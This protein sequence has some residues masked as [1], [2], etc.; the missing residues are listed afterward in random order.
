MK[1]QAWFEM[2]ELRRR[3][4]GAA[5]WIPLR[6]SE[7]LSREGD[8][9]TP[10]SLEEF[11]G[12]GAVAIYPEFRDLAEKLGW[13]DFGLANTSSYASKDHPYKPADV[14]WHNDGQPIGLALVLVNSVSGD[15]PRQWIV[16][17]DLI[18]ALGLLQEGDSW[19][20]VDEGYVEV[21]RQR[22]N[23]E[24]EVIAV[25]IKS[26]FLRDY[27]C[28]RGLALRVV[29][30]HQRW[31]IVQT[32]D[33]ILWAKD[34]SELSQPFERLSLRAWAIGPD[35]GPPDAH[36]AVVKAWRTD[37][38]LE[39]DAPVFG[40]ETDENTD[41]ETSSFVR[42][43]GQ[44][45]YRVEGGL[46][47]EE[48][49][50]PA[51]RSVRVRRDEPKDVL[52]FVVD[53][54]GNTMTATELDDEDIGRWLFF[55]PQ[56]IDAL[57]AYRGSNL[58]WYTENTG[59]VQCSP[60]EPIHFGIDATGQINVYAADVAGKSQWQQQ[61][62]LGH[63]AVPTGPVCAELL[64]AQMGASPAS[65]EAPENHFQNM[66]TLLDK[67]FVKLHG[68]PLFHEHPDKPSM[69]ARMHRFRGLAGRAGV[70]SLA[71]DIARATADALDIATLRKLVP[72]ETKAGLGS[73]K[74]LDAYLAQKVGA[75]KSREIMG[76]LV[77]IYELRLGDAHPASS[78]ISDAFELA[79]VDTGVEGVLQCKQLLYTAAVTLQSILGV[80]RPDEPPPEQLG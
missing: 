66:L 5:V 22:R 46:W 32:V 19:V 27:L 64:S 15:H 47:R 25:E 18:I 55:R 60:G 4:M 1:Q 78:A 44:V 36:V 30:F 49:I 16:H 17:P 23:A 29:Q 37:V 35:G 38:D 40:A 6:R 34:G 11:D 20:R 76:P 48:W 13:S 79:H 31:E 72:P 51:E 26:D 3:R 43:G 75:V 70:L 71:K 28:A 21:I 10:G 33:H 39:Q 7:R 63:S 41:Y 12:I 54:A 24:G 50:E 68:H 80:L 58:S 77:G 53:P 61:V 45:G 62:W 9:A 59:S 8:Y 56:V 52:R 2:A 14:V 65:T 42:P 69:L 74:L 73:L 67:A 57:L